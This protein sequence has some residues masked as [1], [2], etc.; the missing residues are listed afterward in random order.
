MDDSLQAWK[1]ICIAIKSERKYNNAATHIDTKQTIFIACLYKCLIF[2]NRDLNV[3]IN[4]TNDKSIPNILMIEDI[5]I[6]AKH[7]ANIPH[8]CA[9][10]NLVTNKRNI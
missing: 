10:E 6:I 3:E 5:L 1:N 2:D 8:V 7:K 4:F 9:P